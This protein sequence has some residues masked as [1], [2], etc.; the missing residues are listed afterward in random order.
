MRIKVD[1]K[2]KKTFDSSSTL[3]LIK[4]EAAVQ[5]IVCMMTIRGEL[6]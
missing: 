4:N 1:G 3:K 5:I 2:Y 6:N